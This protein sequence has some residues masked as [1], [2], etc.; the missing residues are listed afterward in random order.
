MIWYACYGSNMDFNRFLLYLQG[1]SLMINGQIKTY[2]ACQGD[3]HAPRSSEPY[4]LQ[5][6]FYFAKQS[7]TWNGH[8]VGFISTK[9]DRRSVTFARLYLISTLQFSHLFAVENGRLSSAI[10]FTLFQ[11]NNYQ[12]FDYNFYNRIIQINSNYQGYP[13]STFTNKELLPINS[14]MDEYIRL[15]SN[16][17][18]LTHNLSNQEIASYFKKSKIGLSKNKILKLI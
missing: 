3:T 2:R 17:I 14:P 18:K 13:I 12:D 5:R 15:I 11:N 1:G 8:G 6:R 4:L 16:G 7:G 9:A 10:D